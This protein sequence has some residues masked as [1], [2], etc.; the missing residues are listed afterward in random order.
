ME[1]HI[2]TKRRI[3]SERSTSRALKSVAPIKPRFSK[4]RISLAAGV[5]SWIEALVGP[6]CANRNEGV[7][8]NGVY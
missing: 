2:F 4:I 6:L 8:R 7:Y 1:N 3:K 5:H